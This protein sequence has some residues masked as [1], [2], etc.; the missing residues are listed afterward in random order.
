MAELLK[1]PDQFLLVYVVMDPGHALFFHPNLLHRS[2]QN[3]SESPRWAMIC[4]YNA[5]SNNPYK[6]S[7]HPRY[8]KLDVVP[9]SAIKNVGIRRFADDPSDVA[10]LE[11]KRD[12][13]AKSLLDE[14][15]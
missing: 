10:W 8:T 2:D 11:D 4:C 7:H 9:D 1:R 12:S 3:T 5:A 6:E 15:K 14:E 13:S